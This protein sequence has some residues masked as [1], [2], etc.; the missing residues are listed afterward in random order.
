MRYM[1]TDY[2]SAEYTYEVEAESHDEALSTARAA[3]TD[4]DMFVVIQSLEFIE[5]Q[6][7]AELGQARG[8]YD[9]DNQAWVVDG[10]Y[11]TCGH[12]E[13]MRC[14][15]YGKLHAGEQAPSIH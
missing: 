2:Y 1:M 7:S 13:A 8:R 3:H 14:T 15:C 10:L 12:P 9:Y 5:T 6:V 11:Q 4:P